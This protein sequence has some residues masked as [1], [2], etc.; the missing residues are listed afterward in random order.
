[1]YLLAYNMQKIMKGGEFWEK[2]NMDNKINRQY[3][4]LMDNFNLRMLNKQL[5][6]WQSHI[7]RRIKIANTY[8]KI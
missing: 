4:N 3:L 2:G 1:M 6:I 7:Y 8:R 5:K